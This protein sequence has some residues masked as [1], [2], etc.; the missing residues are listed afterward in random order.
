[1]GCKL[2]LGSATEVEWVGISTGVRQRWVVHMVESGALT[3]TTVSRNERSLGNL[4][5]T[6]TF[7]RSTSVI[8]IRARC[9]DRQE[10]RATSREGRPGSLSGK[11]KDL[12]L[13]QFNVS[14]SHCHEA[15]SLLRPFLP[16]SH[17]TPPAT[18]TYSAY[19]RSLFRSLSNFR[20]RLVYQ[21]PPRRLRLTNY[22]PITGKGV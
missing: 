2:S 15:R 16:S 12:G 14:R 20:P 6:L 11:G 5:P 18:K 19:P 7:G 1:M 22:Q 9:P 10:W 21:I 13:D 3:G 17:V 8:A 4:R